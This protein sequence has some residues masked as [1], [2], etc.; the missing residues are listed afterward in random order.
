MNIPKINHN[1][2][3]KYIFLFDLDGTILSERIHQQVYHDVIKEYY[4]NINFTWDDYL[5]ACNVKEYKG[6]VR[7][8]LKKKYGLSLEEANNISKI[9]KERIIKT[10][11]EIIFIDGFK[12]LF[13]KIKEYEINISI[14]TNAPESYTIFVKNNNELLNSITQ[15]LPREKYKLA[16]PHSE[17]YD[18]AVKLFKK[19]EEKYI[20]GFENSINGINSVKQVADVVFGCYKESYC[21]E[22]EN[23]IL[24]DNYN[25][26]INTIFE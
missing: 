23:I 13:K 21:K 20:I 2:K 1:N 3:N 24:F 19:T 25:D 16:K 10:K 14:V 6:R 8:L 9:K 4:P 26:I 22:C 17:P 18:T 12:N 15:W 5:T 11:H 7:E